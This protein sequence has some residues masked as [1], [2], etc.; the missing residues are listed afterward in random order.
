MVDLSLID[1]HLIGENGDHPSNMGMLAIVEHQI[2]L[3]ISPNFSS[4]G[5]HSIML[6]ASPKQGEGL[7]NHSFL[8][9]KPL[10]SS[11]K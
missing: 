8:L 4:L 3:P 1:G 10:P 6:W 5:N 11:I 7:H 2:I 9:T